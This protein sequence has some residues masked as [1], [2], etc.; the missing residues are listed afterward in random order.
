MTIET[1]T[2]LLYIWLSVSL[3]FP[4]LAVILLRR[5]RRMKAELAKKDLSNRHYEEMLYASKDGYLT[6]SVYKSKDYQYC[7]RR[8]ATMLN[9]SAGEKSTF[10]DVAAAF[11]RADAE[12][13]N[14][15]FTALLKDG[16]SFETIV[17][18]P[19]GK[20]ALSGKTFVVSGVRI[21]SADS[22]INSSCLWFRDITRETD[23]IDRAT[24]DAL[25]C[26]REVEDFRILIDNLPSPV[27]LRD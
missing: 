21:N 18:T 3:V 14:G 26:R 25:A 23:F 2:I 7:S 19:A 22:L 6:H 11:E 8:L 17:R 10:S 9:L 16:K 20:A 24:E 12:K 15:M 1:V 27:W 13:L 5:G 4:L